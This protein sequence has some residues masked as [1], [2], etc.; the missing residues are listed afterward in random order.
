M[1]G[2]NRE[3][4]LTVSSILSVEEDNRTVISNPKVQNQCPASFLVNNSAL[5]FKE[6]VLPIG[7]P[8]NLLRLRVTWV[9]GEGLSKFYEGLANPLTLYQQ[10]TLRTVLHNTNS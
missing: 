6:T 9:L 2:N 5:D 1:Y 3:I 4:K 7:A 10:T 8:L